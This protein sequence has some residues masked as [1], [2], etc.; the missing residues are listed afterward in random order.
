MLSIWED[1]FTSVIKF[2]ARLLIRASDLPQ[3]VLSRLCAARRTFSNGIRSSTDDHLGSDDEVEYNEVFLTP[4][5][6]DLEIRLIVKS[7]TLSV[8]PS[9]K[10][11]ILVGLKR[12]MGPRLTHTYDDSTGDFAPVD[13]TD[14]ILKHARIRQA[15][16]VDIASRE[17]Q[18]HDPT[19]KEEPVKSTGWLRPK[20]SVFYRKD[21]DEIASHCRRGLEVNNWSCSSPVSA[22]HVGSPVSAIGMEISKAS[23]LEGVSNS[24]NEQSN[25]R[26]DCNGEATST[27]NGPYGI[28]K[29]IA[30]FKE[31]ELPNKSA[32]QR[33][34]Q[35][36]SDSNAEVNSGSF[37]D[38]C[39]TPMLSSSSQRHSRASATTG[40]RFLPPRSR[41]LG[42]PPILE[43]GQQVAI[44]G[45]GGDACIAIDNQLSAQQARLSSIRDASEAQVENSRTL[46][47]SFSPGSPTSA[48]SWS[49]VSCKMRRNCTKTTTN[50]T[51]IHADG[52]FADK[53]S[54][55]EAGYPRRLAPVGREFQTDIPDLL[56]YEERKREHTGTSARMVSVDADCPGDWNS[57]Q[58]WLRL[59]TMGAPG[60]SP[61]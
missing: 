44:P 2:R 6:E 52:G 37:V 30:T 39:S 27:D 60:S 38:F 4:K 7:V 40:A 10:T 49:K 25:E 36:C 47:R 14:P 5:L 15:E 12:K 18:E 41:G 54:Q 45:S 29:Q 32:R 20:R 61:A 35:R 53:V 33:R 19:K 28:S 59:V 8:T 24:K 48:V 57:T 31:G 43:G 55:E 26:V 22:V 21:R 17:N 3:D 42:I 58:A 16:A 1:T 13:D 56:P 46:P 11:A 9:P 23:E 51:S 50:N 34:F